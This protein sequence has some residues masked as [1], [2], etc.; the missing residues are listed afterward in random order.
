MPRGANR[1]PFSPLRIRWWI[2]VLPGAAL[3]VPR[4]PGDETPERPTILSRVSS[5]VP[6][7]TVRRDV[8]GSRRTRAASGRRPPGENGH[9]KSDD[10]DDEQELGK[11]DAASKCKKDDQKDK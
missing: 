1:A 6:R 11:K 2:H 10:Q 3:G 7:I 5:L 9:H 4:N 8:P